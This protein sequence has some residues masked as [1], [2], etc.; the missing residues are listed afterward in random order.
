MKANI[1]NQFN[2]TSSGID[3]SIGMIVKNE[4]KNIEKCLDAL[5][6]LRKWLNV[7]IVVTDTG[8]TDNTVALLRKYDIEINYFEWC[9][10]FAKARNYNLSFA[11]GNWF[12]FVDADEHF[13]E[14]I[15]NI[16][17]FI[18]SKHSENHKFATYTILNYMDTRKKQ[19]QE[20]LGTRLAKNT[21]QLRFVGAI[22]E[23]FNVDDYNFYHTRAN[24]HHESYVQ[25]VLPKISE[26]KIHRNLEILYKEVKNDPKNVRSLNQISDCHRALNNM[27]NTQKL[28]FVLKTLAIAKKENQNSRY[29]YSTIITFLKFLNRYSQTEKYLKEFE[30]SLDGKTSYLYLD[31]LYL[32]AT[33]ALEKN[34]V[35]DAEKYCEL[36]LEYFKNCE[37]NADEKEKSTAICY[38]NKL[39]YF[40]KIK[41]F[42]G[43]AYALEDNAEK[44][45]KIVKE[46][47]L[48]LADNNNLATE[49]PIDILAKLIIIT[50]EYSYIY[51][52]FILLDDDQKEHLYSGVYAIIFNKE[53][54]Q[55][56]EKTLKELQGFE[57]STTFGVANKIRLNN[58]KLD[59][60]T[61][62]E[63]QLIVNDNAIYQKKYYNDILKAF[64]LD[65]DSKFLYFEKS[66]LE[67]I[68]NALRF[69]SKNEPD[70]NL[71]C[72]NCIEK[73]QDKIDEL[74]EKEIV[75]YLE[76]AKSIITD[77]KYIDR[78]QFLKAFTIHAKIGIRYLN[79][80]YNEK[81][82]QDT[83]RLAYI[84]S[85]HLA[86]IYRHQAA[87]ALEKSDIKS[88]VAEIK[89]A[90]KIDKNNYSVYSVII[91]FMQEEIRK[92]TEL[93]QEF[94]QL[95]KQVKTQIKEFINQNKIAE[96]KEILEKY[97][98]LNP[99]DA[100]IENFKNQLK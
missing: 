62:S 20:Q 9:K 5:I 72:C 16:A 77:K 17:N 58:Y 23:G 38:F 56:K 79:S 34:I 14:S 12:M 53:L 97:T 67:Y 46:I 68:S 6:T 55:D 70:F 11:K 91:Q 98:I 69:L 93:D 100:E 65:T 59:C 33:F 64:I 4:A 37:K 95:A 99:N 19:H 61:E 43:L 31:A 2:K 75:F 10:D 30:K 92:P 40:Y 45:I 74:D 57:K 32:M 54:I 89:K 3:L 26:G 80:I 39:K 90:V 51:D 83:D 49:L 42:F 86:I 63:I 41:V 44:A 25:N 27:P 84:N 48:D 73:I 22:H 96:A 24:A 35:C 36:Y 78:Q 60:C 21:A 52:L 85:A 81:L 28:E 71:D 66:C 7:Q 94:L 13:D 88:A 8:S 18:K 50:K 82:L 76:V 1:N 87:I 15:I 47:F 29:C